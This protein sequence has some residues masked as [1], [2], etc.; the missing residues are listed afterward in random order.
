MNVRIDLHSHSSASDG[1]TSPGDVV[2]AAADLDIGVLALTDHDTSAGWAEAAGAAVSTGV[3]LVPGMEISTKHQGRGVHV[4]AYLPDPTYPPLVTELGAIMAGRNNRIEA[5]LSGLASAGVHLTPEE[6]RRQAGAQPV[7]G[8]PHVADAMVARSIVR[9]R[10]EAFAGWL[11]PGKPGF[12]VRYAPTTA[13]MIRLVTCAGGA[14]VIAH[15]WGRNS[16]GVLQLDTLRS[17]AAAG[18]VGL[19]VDHQDH[20]AADREQLRG[21]A[22]QL[23]LVVTGS[24]DYH[25]AGKVD[26]ELGCNLTAP[27]QLGRLLAAAGANAS[28]SGRPVSSIV[29]AVPREV[30]A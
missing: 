16:R 24:S 11:D 12:V 20:S 22:Q 27:D 17:L 9:T 8:R 4:L 13:D 26:H 28:A 30:G 3:C 6:V 5:M 25:G 29:G 2:R 19:E 10:R 7:I 14:A 18:L 15:P 1:T 21:L 23:G